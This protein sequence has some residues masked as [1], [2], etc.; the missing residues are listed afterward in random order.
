[1]SKPYTPSPII[2]GPA[3]LSNEDLATV[4]DLL[5]IAVE[6]KMLT[7]G[8]AH[9]ALAILQVNPYH[10]LAVL[11]QRLVLIKESLEEHASLESRFS[12]LVETAERQLEILS[13]LVHAHPNWAS[14]E[15]SNPSLPTKRKSQND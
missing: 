5:R 1:M 10:K 11:G 2:F 7:S 3:N 6:G 4:E 8:S 15:D 12:T 14:Q 9:T 13:K